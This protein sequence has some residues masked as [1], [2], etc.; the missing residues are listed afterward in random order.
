MPKFVTTFLLLTLLTY[1]L[2]FEMQG[3]S[4]RGAA[5]M[6]ANNLVDAV[7]AFDNGLLI[8]PD[9]ADIIGNRNAALAKMQ[10]NIRRGE[11]A[12]HGAA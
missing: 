12:H 4:R 1:L 11:Q 5:L 8:D 3:Y 2:S 6:C 9:N 10:E 7:Q